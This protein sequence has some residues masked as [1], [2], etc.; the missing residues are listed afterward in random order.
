MGMFDTVHFPQ[1][2]NCGACGAQIATTQTKAFACL[3][4]D[5]H[6]GDC[7]ANAEETRIVQEGLCCATA[8]SMPLQARAGSRSVMNP[9]SAICGDGSPT[10]S[11][12]M[13]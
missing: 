11:R 8:I 4:D 6:V 2:V 5:F 13:P 9:C 12:A 1:P 10:V 3:L 7:V